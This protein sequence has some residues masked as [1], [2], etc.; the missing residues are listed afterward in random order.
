MA[1]SE[2]APDGNVIGMGTLSVVLG[3]E[4]PNANWRNGQFGREG[5]PSL[6]QLAV[7]GT[8]APTHQAVS[9]IAA[10]TLWLLAAE[11]K[12]REL[13]SGP[14]RALLEMTPDPSRVARNRAKP[15]SKGSSPAPGKSKAMYVS[16][17]S[18]KSISNFEHNVPGMA[19]SLLCI[20]LP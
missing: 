20:K 2:F 13:L 19:N 6:V 17:D 18:L 7:Q 16:R 8:E 15:K 12:R 1:T 4:Q 9:V 14:A 10:K 3:A 5:P 11:T